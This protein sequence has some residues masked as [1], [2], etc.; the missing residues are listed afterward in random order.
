LISVSLRYTTLDGEPRAI[1]PQRLALPALPTSAFHAI[2]EDELVVRRVGELEVA[3]LQRRAR[4][5]A[6]R[7]DWDGVAASLGKAERYAATN[8]WVAGCLGEL[9]ELAAR[10]DEE[11]FSKEA[12]FSARHMHHRLAGKMESLDIDAAAKAE[13]LRRKFSQGKG[14]DKPRSR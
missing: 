6:R 2:A 1:Q 9:R 4:E 10:K 5:A 3:D 8:P 12:A 7:R 11:L 13:Y 14:Q